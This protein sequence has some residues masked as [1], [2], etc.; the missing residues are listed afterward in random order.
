[1]CTVVRT[2]QLNGLGGDYSHGTFPICGHVF[3]F[4]IESALRVEKGRNC[5]THEND[6]GRPFLKKHRYL[7][8]FVLLLHSA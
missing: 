8:S 2:A 3:T 4:T 7:Y 1:M 6:E 5:V